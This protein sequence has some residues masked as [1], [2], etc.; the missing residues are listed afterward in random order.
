MAAFLADNKP[1]WEYDY[2]TGKSG[3]RF[4]PNQPVNHSPNNTGLTDLPPAQPA[5]IWYPQSEAVDFPLLGSGSNSAVGGPI[6]HQSDFR[7]PARPFPA[8]YEGKWFITDW[9]RGW[10]MAVTIGED[11]KFVSM[12]QFL[13]ELKLEGPID[14]HFGPDGDLYVLEYGRGPYERNREAS[15]LRIEYNKGNRSPVVKVSADKLSGAVPLKV[16]LSST[17]TMDYD[18]DTLHYEWNITADGKAPQQVEG[19]H[20]AVTFSQGGVYQATLTVT[21]AQGA[22]SSNGLTIIAGNEPPVI[23]F[24]FHGGNRSFFFPDQKINYSV[25]VSDKEDGEL[26][27]V[28]K[29]FSAKRISPDSV[30]V[31]IDYLAAGNDFK[32]IAQTL[33][34]TG[35]Q[36]SIR[37]ILADRLISSSNCITCH[38]LNAK[39]L[40]PA[41]TAIAEKY[42]RDTGVEDRLVRKI[43]LGGTGVWGG[44]AMPAHPDLLPEDVHTIVKYILSLAHPKAISSFPVSDGYTTK[45]PVGKDGWGRLVFRASYTD[46]ATEFAPAQSRTAVVLMR[47]PVIPVSQADKYDGLVLN[48]QIN[49][50]YSSVTPKKQGAFLKFNQIDLTGITQISVAVIAIP[51]ASADAKIQIRM[52]GPKGQLIGEISNFPV[53]VKMGKKIM[54]QSMASIEKI[55]GLHDIYFVFGDKTAGKDIGQ[56]KMQAVQFI[57]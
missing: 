26:S 37:A 12:E 50:F 54:N 20:P 44:E 34:K 22:K 6:Y 30:F 48:Y 33:Q 15:L 43:I 40:G 56:M 35:S 8:Y 28:V 27:G 46:K 57:R 18:G 51:T 1:Y 5:F 32:A 49:P 9:T 29:D 10:I 47:N 52:D 19:S 42:Q 13:P 4:D 24:D 53:L 17:G 25:Q 38:S 45:I 36:E 55:N 23:D 11:G 7:S 2:A 41:Y 14:M 39:L 3:K 21:D 31:S 16:N